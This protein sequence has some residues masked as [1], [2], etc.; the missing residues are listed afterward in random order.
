MT[1]RRSDSDPDALRQQRL[2]MLT[3]PGGRLSMVAR[4][5]ITASPQ[6]FEGLPGMCSCPNAAAG[7]LSPPRRTTTCS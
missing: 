4:P 6:R 7:V 5:A 3:G 2:A 1:G